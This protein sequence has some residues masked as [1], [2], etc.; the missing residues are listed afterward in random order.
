MDKQA[1][2]LYPTSMRTQADRLRHTIFFELIGLATC[3]PLAAWILDRDLVKIGAMSMFI[4]ITAMGCN[5]L[6]NLAFDHLLKR[7]GR[8]VHHRPVR[9][10][11]IHAVAFESTLL[12]ITI[13]VVAWWLDMTLWHAF[14]TDLGFALFFLV[15]AYVYN[16]AYDHIFPMPVEKEPTAHQA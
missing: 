6:F 8:P 16:W 15:Y 4:S 7:L 13:P 3:A 5:Y 14:V 11:V 9:L 10:R 2:A 1:G 12:L